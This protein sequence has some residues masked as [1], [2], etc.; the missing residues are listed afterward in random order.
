MHKNS[1]SFLNFFICFAYLFYVF[2]KHSLCPAFFVLILPEYSKFCSDPA[3]SFGK[4]RPDS[5]LFHVEHFRSVR[6]EHPAV[7]AAPLPEW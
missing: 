4:I 1:T 3:V 2:T 5:P 7:P 6:S